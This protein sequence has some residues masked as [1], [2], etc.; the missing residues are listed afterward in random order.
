MTSKSY[1]NSY[2]YKWSNLRRKS[3][4]KFETNKINAQ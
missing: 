1:I 4:T 3:S 2:I